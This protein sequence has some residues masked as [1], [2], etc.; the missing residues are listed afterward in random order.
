MRLEGNDLVVVDGHLPDLND[1]IS[2]KYSCDEPVRPTRRWPSENHNHSFFLACISF[3]E[4]RK[5][6][7]SKKTDKALFYNFRVHA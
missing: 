2:R 7:S 3:N 1:N 4:L 6:I 5:L